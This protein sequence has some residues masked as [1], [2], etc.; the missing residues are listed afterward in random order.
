MNQILSFWTKVFGTKAGGMT[1]L[2]GILAFLLSPTLNYT[3]AHLRARSFLTAHAELN[4]V[5]FTV[6]EVPLQP[7]GIQRYLILDGRTGQPTQGHF[8]LEFNNMGVLETSKKNAVPKIISGGYLNFIRVPGWLLLGS[9]AIVGWG[10]S[11]AI[12]AGKKVQAA[13]GDNHCPAGLQA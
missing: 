11:V 12:R 2:C 1:A 6:I 13:G 9:L 8:V 3:V 4:G 7:D 10:V 5:S